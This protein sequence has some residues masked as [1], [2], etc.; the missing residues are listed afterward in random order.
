MAFNGGRSQTNFSYLQSGGDFWFLNVLKTAQPWSDLNG[1]N[2][3]PVTPDILNTDGYPTTFVNTAG[4]TLSGIGTVFNVPGPGVRRTDVY[5]IRWAGGV[6]ATIYFAG[7]SVLVGNLNTSGVKVQISST[8]IALGITVVGS[9]IVTDL[10][11]I[12]EDDISLY[13]S[14]EVFGVKLKQRLVD[15]N[16]G[17]LR[18]L[19]QQ[20]GNTTNVTT[21]S[22]RRP[23]TYAFYGGPEF[24]LNIYAGSTTNSGNA[25]SC[26]FPSI[27]SST[28]VAWSSG[29]PL[30]NDTI[31]VR[32]NTSATQSGTCSLNV[33]TTGALNI[34]S[35]YSTALSV[36]GNSYPLG[37]YVGTLVYNSTLNAWIKQGGDAAVGI[38]SYGLD[39]G[40]PPELLFRLCKEIGAHPHFVM[41]PLACFPVSDFATGLATYHKTT[42]LD[43]GLATWMVPRYE[44]PNELWNTSGGFYQTHHASAIAT[45]LGWTGVDALF[46][47][48]YGAVMS[49]LGQSIA[50]VYGVIKANV[51]SQTIYKV[52][53]GCQ[54][55]TGATSS[56]TLASG[57]RMTA[58][59]WIAAAPPAQSGYAKDPASDWVTGIAIANY[60]NPSDRF[61]HAEYKGAWNFIHTNAGNPAAQAANVAA[62]V[63][64]VD[65]GPGPFTLSAHRTIQANWKTWAQSYSVQYM[66]GYEGCLSPDFENYDVIGVITGITKAAS[67]IVTLATTEYQAGNYTVSGNPSINGMQILF[68]SNVGG[69]TQIQGLTGTITG[70]GVADGLAA[71]EVRVNI[72]STGFSTYTSGGR[73]NY[74]N[75]AIDMNN[76]R[77]AA[78]LS[79]NLQGYL[80]GNTPH[81]IYKDF[82]DNTGGGFVAEFPSNYYFCESIAGG[83][84]IY[85]NGLTGGPYNI[86]VWG[87]QEDIYQ[88]PD[89]P[90][91]AAMK[92]FNQFT[93][94]SSVKL[95]RMRV[96]H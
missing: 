35:E 36:G 58:A 33:G 84:S 79:P 53:S 95:H 55:G 30:H 81:S 31:S 88:T 85:L 65:S 27:H 77:Q 7:G 50:A 90:Q 92:V 11:F 14:G 34:L 46:H 87:I 63:D 28:G 48:W 10:Q 1:T 89:Q 19:N 72:N 57:G 4:Q 43:T 83:G 82:C 16:C 64:T 86:T 17:V 20:S 73:C 15:V 70:V 18:F 13:D 21:W 62:Y 8:T 42:Y 41:P 76:F 45:A 38:K 59:G 29:G 71:N 80:Y 93:P 49:L 32:F 96:K 78:K 54:T 52:I 68:D 9:P 66:C 3:Y 2:D 69:M 67:A 23:Q 44:G 75:S 60:F 6:G 56:N 61:T 5:Y 24:R 25:Y 12:H 51:K 40:V 37:G 22:T 74:V 26:S 91:Y 39:N 47:E 94:P